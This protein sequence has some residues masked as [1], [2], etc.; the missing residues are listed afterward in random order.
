MATSH[1]LFEKAKRSIPGGVN[2]PVRAFRGVGGTPVFIDHGEGAYLV[3]VQGKRYVDHVLSWGPL[4]LGHAHPEVVEAVRRAAG[5]GFS[6]GA[7]TAAEIELAEKVRQ[8]Y[9]T[10]E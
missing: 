3:D 9:P 6:F 2:S 4:L 7:P 5:R 8:V 1:E 10:L